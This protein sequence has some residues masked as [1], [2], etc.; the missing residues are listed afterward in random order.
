MI[1]LKA[2]LNSEMVSDMILND[3]VLDTAEE[4]QSLEDDEMVTRQATRMQHNP[5]LENM[6]QRLEQME[7]GEIKCSV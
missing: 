6:Y 3:L 5:T 4:L 2:Q 1:S 7:V